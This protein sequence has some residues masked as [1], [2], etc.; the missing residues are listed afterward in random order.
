MKLYYFKHCYMNFFIEYKTIC[1][2]IIKYKT[3]CI[4]INILITMHSVDNMQSPPCGININ[5]NSL[6]NIIQNHRNIFLHFY[7]DKIHYFIRF[8]LG[9]P[10]LLPD[11]L[12]ILGSNSSDSLFNI[13]VI[14][15]FYTV[16]LRFA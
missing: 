1:I 2:F 11:S 9:Q 13:P 14:H 3:I 5:H 7:Y 4:F 10:D 12:I 8:F 6:C 16:N 15:Y